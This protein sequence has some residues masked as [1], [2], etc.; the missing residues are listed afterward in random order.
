M[1]KAIFALVVFWMLSAVSVAQ[2]KSVAY[3]GKTKGGHRITF[4][5]AGNKVTRVRTGVPTVCLPTT[6]SSFYGSRSGVDLFNPPG[7]F[8]IGATTKRQK[9]QKTAMWHAEVTKY[10]TVK[11]SKKGRKVRGSLQATF[12]YA[13]PVIDYYGP[14]LIIYVCRSNTEFSAKPQ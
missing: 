2:A 6:S 4:K 13:L 8:K 3:T 10:Y 11:L 12:S 7:S 9:L 1:R 5:K 14:R